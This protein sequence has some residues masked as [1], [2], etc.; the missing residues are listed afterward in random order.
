MTVSKFLSSVG[1]P[2]VVADIFALLRGRK[3]RRYCH[4]KQARDQQIKECFHA[5]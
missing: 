4:A 3:D 1:L 2:L 5:N